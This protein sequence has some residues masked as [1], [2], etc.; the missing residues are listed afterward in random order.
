MLFCRHSRMASACLP[1]R[2]VLFAS[3]G[4][5]GRGE[6]RGTAPLLGPAAGDAAS[7]QG[8][9]PS[10]NGQ[11]SSTMSEP[12]MRNSSTVMPKKFSTL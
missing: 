12:A 5:C 7:I 6:H 9:E 1:R 11:R 4:L 3:K 10:A 8:D 2:V